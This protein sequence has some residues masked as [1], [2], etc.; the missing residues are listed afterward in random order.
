M[1]LAKKQAWGLAA[2]LL[3]GLTILSFGLSSNWIQLIQIMSPGGNEL[4]FAY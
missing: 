3:L 2:L 1:V 4:R